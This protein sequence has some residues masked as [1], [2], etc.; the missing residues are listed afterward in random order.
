MD[1]VDDPPGYRQIDSA[2]LAVA[3]AGPAGVHEPRLGVVPGELL[4]QQSGVHRGMPHQKR[5]AEA[6]GEGGL[7]LG[8]THFGSGHAGGVAGK[9]VIHRLL[10]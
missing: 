7:R 9:E 6:G 3:A 2:A 4:S 1:A 8:N 5:C 10:P